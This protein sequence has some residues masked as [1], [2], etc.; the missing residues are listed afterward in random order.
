[1]PIEM[2]EVIDNTMGKDW[3]MKTHPNG[4]ITIWPELFYQKDF[5]ENFAEREIKE[6]QLFKQY[7]DGEFD[8]M[9]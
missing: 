5:I 7:R 8:N 9:S 3:K 4:D 1:V 2:F 6:R